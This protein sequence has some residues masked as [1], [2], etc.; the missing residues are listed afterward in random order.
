V[1]ISFV[2]GHSSN[3]EAHFRLIEKRQARRVAREQIAGFE[4]TD[5]DSAP[6]PTGGVKGLR[7][8]KKDKLREAAAAATA[9]GSA[10]A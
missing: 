10:V 2:S 7:K 1:A 8:S 3:G 4:P 9:A 5:L 6:S